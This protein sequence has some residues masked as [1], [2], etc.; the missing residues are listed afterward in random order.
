MQLK[1]NINPAK[2]IVVTGHSLGGALAHLCALPIA[3]EL[4]TRPA[5]TITFAQP[6]IGFFGL[7]EATKNYLADSFFRITKK[8][9]PVPRLPP[10]ALLFKHPKNTE[11]KKARDGS[12]IPVNFFDRHIWNILVLLVI[13]VVCFLAYSNHIIADY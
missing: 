7:A 8:L 11:F 6:R 3:T 12:G 4:H 1:P 9:D 10:Y 5:L 2:P 13:A